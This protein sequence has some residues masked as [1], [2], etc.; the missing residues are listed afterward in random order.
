MGWTSPRW[1]ACWAWTLRGS[2]SDCERGHCTASAAASGCGSCRAS[3]SSTA[4][5]SPTWARFS[6]SC[7]Q[8]FIR[9]RS[10]DSSQ[11]R[12]RN[13]RHPGASRPRHGSG[14]R[15]EVRRS[16]LWRWP[17]PSPPSERVAARTEPG[18]VPRSA[19][20]RRLRSR[21]AS[22]ARPHLSYV[23]PARRRVTGVPPKRATGRRGASTITSLAPTA[24]SGTA[25]CAG[26]PRC[27][28]RSPRPARTPTPSTA[29]QTAPLWCFVSP[30]PRFD[31][32]GWTRAGWR[33]RTATPPSSPAPAAAPRRGRARYTTTIQTWTACTTRHAERR[34]R[35]PK[36][37]KLAVDERLR[38]YVQDR[39][40]GAVTD[41]EGRP[42]PNV[43]WKGRR[44][45]RRADRRWGTAWSPEQISRRLRLDFPDDDSMLVS[46]E[47][48]YQSL[49][50]Q[51]RDG[52][53]R[54]LSACL[55]VRGVLCASRRS[56]AAEEE[57]SSSPRRP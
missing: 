33:P 46:H 20:G 35:R 36:P 1:P 51:G 5:K 34:S 18:A 55:C 28:A 13:S 42:I 10:K 48:I 29:P 53:R 43:P 40:S 9:V 52:V 4:T 32:S 49:Y 30:P 3:N 54:E 44:H 21:R 57:R 24:A 26:P 41:A 47:A 16:P 25:Q 45:G 56:V 37:V 7:P 11:H 14:S 31:Y 15:P 19:E 27:W 17:R 39:L 2:G 12:S 6:A 22:S 23:G 8:T 38:D 50:V